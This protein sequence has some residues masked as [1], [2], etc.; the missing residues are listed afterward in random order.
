MNQY[1]TKI[2]LTDLRMKSYKR[3]Y[4]KFNF[5]PS[6]LRSISII[7]ISIVVL[8]LIFVINFQKCLK[9]QLRAY[10]VRFGSVYAILMVII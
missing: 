2:R 3:L 10:Y 7:N 6:H 1:I 9:N 8:T 5:R 4:V